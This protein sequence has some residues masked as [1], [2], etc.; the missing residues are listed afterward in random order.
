M[1]DSSTHTILH[2]AERAPVPLEGSLPE[3][4]QPLTH[5]DVH[6]ASEEPSIGN[7]VGNVEALQVAYWWGF[8]WCL[9]GGQFIPTTAL[10]N[11]P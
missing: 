9:L 4:A 7:L 1:H 5:P 2:G 11:R 10:T 6:L 8:C 3:Q